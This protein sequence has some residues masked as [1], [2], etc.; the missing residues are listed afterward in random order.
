MT[1]REATEAAE[2][3]GFRKTNYRSDGQPVF[4]RGNRYITPDITGHNGG[5]WKMADSVRNL[6]S[7]TRRMG[8][9]DGNLNRIGD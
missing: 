7:R 5:V 9:F 6:S 3:L 4:K 8:S 2:R 1:A